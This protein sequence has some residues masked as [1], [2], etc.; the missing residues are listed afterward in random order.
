VRHKRV[1]RREEL[2]REARS[3]APIVSVVHPRQT[4]QSFELTL[5]AD[6]RPWASTALYA[7]SDGYLASWKYDINDRVKKGDIM[8]VIAA[9]DVDAQL[10]QAQADLNQQKTNQRLAAVTEERYRG[11]IA[12]RG[13]TQQQL[14]QVHATR[15]QAAANVASAAATVDRLKAL[16]GFE[17]IVAPFDGVVT[18]RNYDVG[19]LIS[20]STSGTGQELFE[21]QEDDR[22][23]V[24]VNVPQPDS[25]LLHYGQPVELSLE[26]NYPGHRFHGIVARSAGALD[27]TTRTLRTELD[28]DNPPPPF[29]LLAGMYAEA[30]FQISRPQPVLTVPTSA[31]LFEPEGKEVAVVVGGNRIHLKKIM[32][33]TDYGLELEALSGLDANDEVVTNPGEQLTEGLTVEVERTAP[34]DANTAPSAQGGRP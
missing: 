26:R 15:E 20:A 10:E 28:F 2:A 7:R 22:L 30:I 1:S 12:V 31:L 6:V 32:P 8:A 24:F 13:V 17:R 14:D 11:L 27:P 18:V 19:A 3:Q 34:A 25:L 21:V 4:Q 29:H 5:P 33:G 23:R 9:P 16:V